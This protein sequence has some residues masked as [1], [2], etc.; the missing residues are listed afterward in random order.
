[1]T[2]EMQMRRVRLRRRRLRDAVLAMAAAALALPAASGCGGEE[3]AAAASNQAKAGDPPKKKA[4]ASGRAAAG[5]RGRGREKA[6]RLDTYS[7]IEEQFRLPFGERDFASDAGGDDN[8]DPFRSFV[9]RQGGGPRSLREAAPIQPTD[10]CTERNIRAPGHAIRDLR[11]IGLILR[12]TRSY[13]QFR[14][15]SGFGWI[16]QLRDCLGKEKAVVEKIG[17]GFVTLE[18]VPEAGTGN[19]PQ[20]ER[21]DIPLH[22]SE[23][24]ADEELPVDAAGMPIAGGPQ[25]QAGAPG[26]QGAPGAAGAPGVGAPGAAGTTSNP[27]AP[28]PSAPASKQ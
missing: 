1:M 22:A 6:G 2:P 19:Q 10:V 15:P 3:P 9:I 24:R 16:V 26:A 11:L 12:G 21:R 13:A 28:P 17:A 4:A 27:P 25:G 5:G 7:Q 8:R 14:D 18:V 23:L 20:A